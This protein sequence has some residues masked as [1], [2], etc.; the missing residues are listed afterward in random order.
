M[1]NRSLNQSDI[2]DKIKDLCAKHPDLCKF[3]LLTTAGA[4]TIPLLLQ[5]AGFSSLGPVAGS[6]AAWWQSQIGD[7]A[8]GSLFAY[9]QSLGMM[10][11][12]AAMTGALVGFAGYVWVELRKVTLNDEEGDK[13][14]AAGMGR[15][16]MNPIHSVYR[17][18]RSGI[19]GGR[20]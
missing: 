18:M 7:V 16:E 19:R 15:S 14:S 10:P 11:A 13:K 8:A 9:L 5:I 1:A 6:F 17:V 12:T 2:V 20:F 4:I 3:I